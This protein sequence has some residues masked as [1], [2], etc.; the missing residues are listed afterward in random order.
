MNSVYW[1]QRQARIQEKLSKQSERKI[2]KQLIKYYQSTA[3][4]VIDD[5]E[6]VYDKIL[7]QKAEGKE[8][9]PALLYK[10]DSYW[11]MQGQLRNELRKL[12]EKQVALL[13][14]EFEIN[15]FDI[16]YSIAP[17]GMKAF[18]TIDTAAAQQMINAVW[19]ADGKTFSQRI[20]ENTERLA[21]TL[22]EQLIHI[23]TTGKK[24][25][26]LKHALQERFGVSYSRANTLVRTELTHIQTVAA[27]KRYEDYGLNRYEILGND[28]DSCGNHSVNCHEMDGQTFLY[29]EMN[30]GVNA[31]PFHPN[32][33]CSII[34]VVE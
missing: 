16:Y 23:A 9:T 4:Q 33:K 13:T 30:V 20:W 10:L 7:L 6:K 26:E 32:C 3:K 2:K 27:A 1:A 31:P 15:F 22:N 21:D 28:D 11:Q 8:V 12:G 34:P 19:L 24:T 14:K 5:F 29:S 25:T 17:E 18:S